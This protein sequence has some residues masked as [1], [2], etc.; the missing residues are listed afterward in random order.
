MKKFKAVILEDI[1]DLR[2][3]DIAYLW[4]DDNVCK[5]YEDCIEG[6]IRL[7]ASLFYKDMKK[8]YPICG[9]AVGV[10]EYVSLSRIEKIVL[11]KEKI[12]EKLKGGK[13]EKHN[14]RNK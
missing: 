9:Y 2:E 1:D 8:E 14:Q 6:K 13:N 10:I 11:F 3:R 7:C 4:T 12:L 5:H